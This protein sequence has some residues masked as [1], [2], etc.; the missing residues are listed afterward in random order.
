MLTRE[1]A[2]KTASEPQQLKE[3]DGDPLSLTSSLDMEKISMK[4]ENVLCLI[5]TAPHVFLVWLV[6]SQTKYHHI[7]SIF[8]VSE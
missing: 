5:Y 2:S 6:V 3:L 8:R 1:D 7:Q 4:G